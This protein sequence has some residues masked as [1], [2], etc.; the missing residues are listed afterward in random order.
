MAEG[1]IFTRVSLKKNKGLWLKCLWFPK[2]SLG[3]RADNQAKLVPKREFG[4]RE[5]LKSLWEPG[6]YLCIFVVNL[7][8][9]EIENNNL[10]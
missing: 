10:R 4:E 3:T 5:K 7:S 2:S 8:F 1:V 9:K 6:Q